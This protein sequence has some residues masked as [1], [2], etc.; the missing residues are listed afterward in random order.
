M[1][2]FIN[3]WAFLQT[4]R[5]PS[6]RYQT[7]MFYTS[8]ERQFSNLLSGIG[9]RPHCAISAI[10]MFFSFITT[11]TATTLCAHML[12]ASTAYK[13]HA[14]VLEIILT[15][16]RVEIQ[17]ENRRDEILRKINKYQTGIPHTT[18]GLQ[19]RAHVE[20]SY[21]LSIDV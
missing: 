9:H 20:Q 12:H 5:T 6:K 7:H 21:K 4:L 3:N 19:H 2:F 13:L 8:I 11:P 17:P 15:A 16:L 1:G 18:M 10:F 14:H